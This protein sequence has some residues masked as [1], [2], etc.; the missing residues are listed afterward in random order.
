MC[1][2]QGRILC[3]EE[4]VRNVDIGWLI[5]ILGDITCQAH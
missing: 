3:I 5:Y 1:E 4:V 2:M